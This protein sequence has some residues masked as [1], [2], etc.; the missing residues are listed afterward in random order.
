MGI[1]IGYG[2]VDGPI[3]GVLSVECHQWRA[4]KLESYEWSGAV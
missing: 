2:R 4:M 3:S 1:A